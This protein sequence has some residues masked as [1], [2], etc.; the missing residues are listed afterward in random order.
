[1]LQIYGLENQYLTCS[2]Y[3]RIYLLYSLANYLCEFY[4]KKQ[5]GFS[6]DK[7]IKIKYLF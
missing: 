5:K 7:Y 3:N 4:L 6:I 1:M 2:I